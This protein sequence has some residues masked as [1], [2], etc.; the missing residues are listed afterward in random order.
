MRV[1]ITGGTGFVGRHLVPA[2]EKAGHEP[3][4]FSRSRPSA[5]RAFDGRI[6][7]FEWSPTDEPAPLEA[8]DG[9]EA[10][11]NLMG[12]NIASGRW[13]EARKRRMR[14]SRVL[15][16]RHLVQTINQLSNKPK[17][18]V[19][20][21]AVGAYGF[22]GDEELDERAETGSGFLPQLALD[23]ERE[24]KQVEAVRLVIPR[25]GLVLGEN[26]GA[27]DKMGTIFKFGLG[28]KVGSGKQW[29]SWIHIHDLVRLIIT[30]IKQP[31]W[32]GVFN[33]VAP[34]PERNQDFTKKLAAALGRPAILP[35]PAFALRLAMGEMADLLLEGQRVVPEAA[36]SKGFAFNYPRLQDALADLL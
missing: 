3:V 5:E 23:W 34:Y 36:R 6:R 35:A 1:L 22:R 13:S 24:A 20:A 18:L 25:I 31:E 19:S 11:V 4:V 2:L 8:F 17:V 21:G 10:V 26:D 14:D 7:V 15:G 12:E 9:V 33:A 27:L 32:R 29:M 30:A 16:T 28:G